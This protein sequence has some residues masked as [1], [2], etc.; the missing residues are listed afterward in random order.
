MGS[1]PKG[2]LAGLRIVEMAGIGPG[3][4]CGMMLA[5][6]GAEVIRVERPGAVIEHRDPLL[7]SRVSVA[8]DLKD[9]ADLARLIDLVKGADGLIEGYRP[10]VMERL[11][12]GPDVLLAANPKLVYGRMTGWGQTGPYAP[13]AGHDINYVALSGLLHTIGRADVPPVPA[14]NYVGDFGGGGMMLAFGMVTALLAV[15]RGGP[16]QVIDCAMWEGAALLGTMIYGFVQ[17]GRW[18]DKREANFLDGAAH[19]YDSYECADGRY[20][21]IGAIEPQFYA[22]LRE[23]LGIA[24]DPDFDPQDDEAG[25]PRLS[26]RIAAIFKTKTRDEWCDLLEYGD[27]CF[28][29]ILSLSEAPQ[30]PHAKARDAFIEIDGVVQPAPGPRFSATPAPAPRAYP[31]NGADTKSV[32]NDK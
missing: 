29:P 6:H 31:G 30:H 19:F 17:N 16:G 24:D 9:P 13:A 1:E 26:E 15:Q 18:V 4:F 25:W 14:G 21:A 32:F 2:A 7:R 28:A 22:L 3:P 10:G 8:L 20:V 27:A 12:L 5:D 11:G 23:K